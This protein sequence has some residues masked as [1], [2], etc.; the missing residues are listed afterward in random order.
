MKDEFYIGWEEK[1]PPG[2]RRTTRRAVA[3]VLAVALLAP[4]ALA[5]SQRLIGKGMFEWGNV[6]TFSGVL[7]AS[8][9]PHLLV[10]RP[11]KAA[12]ASQSAY[13]LVAPWK[14]GLNPEKLAAWDGKPVKLKGAL[15]YRDNQTMIETRADW[16]Q[17]GKEIP[18][19]LT[20]SPV[21]LGKQTLR[22]EIVDSKCFLGVMNPGQLA[23]HRGCAIR[24]ISGGVSP[25]LVVRP[26]RGAAICLLLV[27]AGGKPVNRE[28]L[29]LVA[30]PV[31]VTG[32]VERQGELLVMRADPA[33]YRRV[34]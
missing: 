3:L 26:E 7:R 4:L 5:V 23:P 11:G 14:F 29:D 18:A 9:Y 22:G 19:S 24:C 20:P 21:Q 16:I 27:S 25:I 34:R 17:D 6:K 28:V 1:A 13:Y 31:E 12:D 15:I 33:T 2:I 8:P 10:A 32:E 30:E